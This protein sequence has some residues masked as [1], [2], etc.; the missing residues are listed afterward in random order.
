MCVCRI[1]HTPP[2]FYSRETKKSVFGRAGVQPLSYQ[3]LGRQLSYFATGNVLRN[4][5]FEQNGYA[6]RQHAGSR[7]QGRPRTAWA[8][9]VYKHAVAAAGS[10]QQLIQFLQNDTASQKSWQT[11]VRRYCPELANT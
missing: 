10:E 11:A 8:T 7:K 2:D 5:V 4:S 3:L 1:L 9:A 6:L